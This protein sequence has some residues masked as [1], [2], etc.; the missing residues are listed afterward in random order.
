MYNQTF[1]PSVFRPIAPPLWY[2]SDGDLTVGPVPTKL[3]LRGV[4]YG[5]V[6]DDCWVRASAPEAD[7]RNVLAVREIA[8]LNGKVGPRL[9][10]EEQLVEWTRPAARSRDEEELAHNVTWLSLVATGA[11]SAM[12]HYRAPRSRHFVTRSIVGPM[13]HDQF[14]RLLPE[15]DPLLEA[16]KLGRPIMGPPYGPLEDALALRMATSQGGVGA[17]AM[18]PIFWRGMLRGLLELS[19]PGHAFRREDLKTAERIAQ[20]A[21]ARQA[22]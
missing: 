11:E 18:I 5:R 7:W 8:A 22:N 1:S 2:V 20:H 4:E 19:R 15:W 13:S 3:L 10:S 6:P 16:A 17:A 12:F 14:G 9:P 21:L